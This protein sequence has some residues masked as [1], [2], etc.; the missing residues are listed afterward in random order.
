MATAFPLRRN[1]DP[2]SIP[3]PEHSL[4]SRVSSIPGPVRRGVGGVALLGAVLFS[5]V[6]NAAPTVPVPEPLVTVTTDSGSVHRVLPVPIGGVPI[7]IDVDN[8]TLLGLLCPDVDVSIG[9]LAFDPASPNSPIVPNIVIARDPLAL[10]RHSVAPPL[11]IDTKVVIDDILNGKPLATVHYGYDTGPDQGV[12]PKVT[13]KLLGPLTSGFIDP[14]EASVEAPGFNGPLKLNVSAT[15]ETLQADFGLKYNPMPEKL[16]FKMVNRP[17]GLDAHYDEQGPNPDVQ[18]QANADL[19]TVGADKLHI[20]ATIERMPDSLDLH[21]TG[22][23][24]STAIDYQTSTPVLAK[25]DITADY[26]DRTPDDKVVTNAHIVAQGVPSHL[27][28]LLTQVPDG[29]GGSA[30][31]SIK[32]NALGGSEIDGVDVWACNYDGGQYCKAQAEGATLPVPQLQPTQFVAA[33]TRNVGGIIRYRVAG[34]LRGIRGATFQR[35]GTR[36]DGLDVTTDMGG[37]TKPLHALLDIDNRGPGT[38]PADAQRMAL[39]ATVR[40]LPRTI[41]ARFEPGKG[42]ENTHIRYESPQTVD[43]D[44]SAEI[45][46]GTAS[47]CGASKVTCLTA[48]VDKV[49]Q[50]LDAILPGEGGT[51]FNLHS[52]AGASGTSPDV[53]AIVDRTPVNVSE[54]TYADIRL[55]RVPA[56]VRGRLDSSAKGVLRAAEFHACPFNFTTQSCPTGTQ[57]ALGSVQFTVRDRPERD[58]LPARPDTKTN[59]V[60]MLSR[61]DGT[62]KHFEASGRVDEIRNVAFRQRDVDNDG[63]ADGTLGVSVDAGDGH[64]PFQAIVDGIAPVAAA[65]SS[66]PL[67]IGT[68]VTTKIDALVDPLPGNFSAC[69]RSPDD[70]NAPPAPGSLPADTLLA[71]CDKIDVLN[72]TASNPLTVTP[73][74]INYTATGEPKIVASYQTTGLQREKPTDAPINHTTRFDATIAKLP[75]SLRADVITPVTPDPSKGI[76]GR[77]LEV[78]YGAGSTVPS[79][80]AHLETRRASSLCADPRVNRLATCL[81]TTILSL[82]KKL[83]VTY[84]P[85]P[86]VGDIDVKVTRDAGDPHPS[87]NPIDLTTVSPNADFPLTKPTSKLNLHAGIDDL[88]DHLA[89]KMVSLHTSEDPPGE[90][91][92][93][94][95]N[96][97]ACPDGPCDGIGKIDFTASNSLIGDL[98]PAVPGGDPDANQSFSFVNQD[99]DFRAKGTIT[100]LKEIGFSKLGGD[101]LPSKTTSLRASFGNGDGTDK[102]RAYLLRDATDTV[103]GNTD[104]QLVDAVISKVPK[105]L[106][107]CFRPELVAPEVPKAAGGAFGFCETAA[108]DKLAVQAKLD[109]AATGSGA[110]KPDI[111]VRKL[112]IGVAG[113]SNQLQGPPGLP[114]AP[115]PEN[116]FAS[117]LRING[118]GERIEALVGSGGADGGKPDILVEGHH[119]ND[120][121]GAPP[122]A[123]ADRVSFDVRTFKGEAGNQYPFA[124]LD[125]YAGNHRDPL[126]DP[127]PVDGSTHNYLKLNSDSSSGRTLI[128]GS[129]PD[130]RRL[131][132]S[133][134]PCDSTDPRFPAVSSFTS[135]TQAPSYTCVR[136]NLAPGRKLGFQVRTLSPGSVNAPNTV[137]SLEDGLLDSVPA[138]GDGLLLTLATAPDTVK[139]KGVCSSTVLPPCRPPILSAEAPKSGGQVSNLQASAAIGPMGMLSDLA[140]KVPEDEMSDNLNYEVPPA[141]FA[142]NKGVRMKL[143]TGDNGTAV[144]ARVNLDLPNF[145]DFDPPTLYG[146]ARVTDDQVNHTG[147]EPACK[148]KAGEVGNE[149]AGY[150]A[151]DIALKL[152]GADDAHYGTALGGDPHGGYL[153]RAAIMIQDFKGASQTIIT[154]A[155][156]E[157]GDASPRDV[158]PETLPNDPAADLG[159]Q[160]PNHLDAQIFIRERFHA[161]GDNDTKGSFYQIDGRVSKPLSLALRSEEAKN[162]DNKNVIGQTMSGHTVPS[163]EVD[164]RNAPGLGDGI[165]NYTKPTFRLRAMTR[166]KH[167]DTSVDQ[168]KCNGFNEGGGRTLGFGADFCLFTPGRGITRYTLVGLNARPD[169]GQPPARTIVAVVDG[170]DNTHVDLAGYQNVVGAGQGPG[171]AAQIRPSAAL[172][173]QPFVLGLEVGVGIGIV[174]GDL[175]AILNGDLL[176]HAGALGNGVT[177]MGIGQNKSAIELAAENGT[178]K[179]RTYLDEQDHVETREEALFGLISSTQ[180][181]DTPHYHQHI[182]FKQCTFPNLGIFSSTTDEYTIGNGD[183]KAGIVLDPADANGLTGGL[184]DSISELLSPIACAFFGTDAGSLVSATSPLPYYGEP[185]HPVPDINAIATPPTLGGGAAVVQDLLVDAPKTFCGTVRARKITVTGTGSIV[186]GAPGTVQHVTIPASGG[187]DAITVDTPCT[188]SLVISA[189]EIDVQSGGV[190]SANALFD[191]PGSGTPAALK[192]GGAGHFG[193]GGKGGVAGSAGGGSYTT[194]N[195]LTDFGSPGATGNSSIAGGKGG[196]ALKLVADDKITISGTVS[197][198]GSDGN[199]SAATCAAGSGSGGG[200]GGAVAITANRVDIPGQVNVNGGKGGNGANGGGGGGGGHVSVSRVVG[201]ALAGHLTATHGNL[202]AK[203]TGCA[204]GVAGADGN[205][206]GGTII[207][208]AAGL[209][210]DTLNPF[211]R[212]S[213]KLHVTALQSGGGSLEVIVCRTKAPQTDPAG[214]STA[215]LKPSGATAAAQIAAADACQLESFGGPTS[216]TDTYESDPVVSGLV[217]HN[218]YGFFAIAAK[219]TSGTTD[220]LHGGTCSFQNLLPSDA[221]VRVLSDD[222]PPTLNVSALNGKPGC[223]DG[224]VGTHTALCLTQPSGQLSVDGSAPGGLGISN[225]ACVRNGT[226]NLACGVGTNDLPLVEGVNDIK[227]T[228]TDASNVTTERHVFWFV[229]SAAPGK[230]SI[231]LSFADGAG[232]NG[233]HNAKPS[234]T[235]NAS[236]PNP[237]SGHDENPISVIIDGATDPAKFGSANACGGTSGDGTSASCSLPANVASFVPDEGKHSF[238][239]TMKDRAGNV[240]PL[241]DSVAMQVDHQA[242]IS[243]SVLGPAKP[244]GLNDWYVTTPFFAFSARDFAGGSGIDADGFTDSGVFYTVD[245]GPVE[246]FDHE[247]AGAPQVY[248]DHMLRD[249]THTICSWAVDVAGNSEAHTCSLPI[250]VDTVAPTTAATIAPAAPNGT[251]S[252]YITRPN[253]TPDASDAAPSSTLD[254][255][256]YQIDSNGW[257]GVTPGAVQ[258]PMPEGEHLIRVRS[259]DKAGNAAT[260]AERTVRTDLSDPV[261]SV[262]GLPGANIRGWQRQ[263]TLLTLAVDDGRDSSGADGATVAIDGGG[264]AS[265]LEPL[266]LTDGNHSLAIRPRDRAGRVG[267]AVTVPQRVDT[268]SP[269]VA[270]SN[271][272]PPPILLFNATVFNFSIS[273]TLA[274]KVKVAVDVYDTLGNVVRRLVV[275][276]DATGFSP[277]GAFSVWW[278]GRDSRNR[279]ALPGLYTFRVEAID[280]AGNTVMSTDSPQFL[281]I[282]GVLP[283]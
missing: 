172:R 89:A 74:S 47:G 130:I 195:D 20:G 266:T 279:G 96:L 109:D 235:V 208:R 171:A 174:G 68:P 244:D 216:G 38:L 236:D 103:T 134:R 177:R 202:G 228:L 150:S 281:I 145:L 203:G 210:R 71:P 185:G 29:K 126:N 237:T 118:L 169:A 123:V 11:K 238:V 163:L 200:S 82:P 136:A 183:H 209:S 164:L 98:L 261:V 139:D 147:D 225:V 112:E 230:P 265:Y 166:D 153:G 12:P 90:A 125:T 137:T 76:A 124:P 54:R 222:T 44:A 73:L 94:K 26:V 196:G 193:V 132:L 121:A 227:V 271:G 79:I 170:T 220:C 179:V 110:I 23:A 280:D 206:G 97:N 251:N 277:T 91:S 72:R 39:D 86:A 278:D 15:T 60:V 100:K 194:N 204:D 241:S 46:T 43:I 247:S 13:A 263:P 14:L 28:G 127:R 129:I 78:G 2:T 108:A 144:R 157:D 182:N 36:K 9:L 33:A 226:T 212:D 133:P 178:A 88:T 215:A 248:H 187:N 162:L 25:P 92:L 275:P 155:P 260:V 63:I 239:A 17:D 16:H 6:A 270:V 229:D 128:Q 57:Q 211:V 42:A 56:E 267:P 115:P 10:L 131:A 269:A 116:P 30:L 41:H 198:S 122:V 165:E 207:N 65:D 24:G 252:F 159:V 75:S 146:C 160:L 83:A 107:V 35:V 232:H 87:F 272:A 186:P 201:S 240:S 99:A 217:A 8:G 3:A 253:V 149:N 156:S 231:G 192:G 1:A 264:A 234:L 67:I 52:E 276:G 119:L 48:R 250:K 120:G 81:D 199:N 40:P 173:E 59:S 181:F 18:L 114:V 274:A 158:A 176:L 233:W 102:L 31:D 218:Y 205:T 175:K 142:A 69:V 53:R 93:Q 221:N 61:S 154:G 245:G 148:F 190:I 21:Y 273:D 62:T 256:Q 214:I 259:F 7:P 55:L 242:P 37:G 58:G 141:D 140:Q 255:T 167:T 117:A 152:V 34:R 51:D 191:A 111:D 27:T 113:A 66:D 106:N 84:D 64:Q 151:K 85:D 32:F 258:V 219:R 189:S 254:R 135:P 246:R 282:L 49:P 257:I 184:F 180:T 80:V 77:K 224:G 19:K 283:L 168:V 22:V 188:G 5:I 143:G 223:P 262:A 95:I 50:V 213:V 70:K 268:R 45:D 243:K 101:N 105:A 138:G 161:P 4:R 104:H 197:A 249:G